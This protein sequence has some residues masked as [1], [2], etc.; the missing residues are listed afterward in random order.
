MPEQVER[1]EFWVSGIPVPQGSHT[2]GRWGGI[3][4]S[5]KALE[6]WRA[7]VT[8]SAECALAGRGGFPK[9]AEVYVLL[10]FYMPRGATVKRR[11]P[12]VKPDIDKC[13]RAIFDSLTA[14][15]VWADDGQVVSVHAQQFYSDDGNPGVRV[16][17]GALA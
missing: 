8:G 9:G 16:V 5:N 10:D 1:V 15:K 14:A 11:R 13:V 6:P 7:A 3:Y 2:V 12:T 17:V 4:D